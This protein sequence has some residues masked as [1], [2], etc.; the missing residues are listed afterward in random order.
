MTQIEI[1]NKIYDE[2]NGNWNITNLHGV[3]LKNCLI[4]PIKQKYYSID[5]E[6]EVEL[7]TVLEESQDHNGYK[8]FYDEVEDCYGLGNLYN[9]DKNQSNNFVLTSL[10][11]YGTFLE[12]LEMM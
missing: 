1:Q 8:I 5:K 11:L 6:Q 2:I 10:G 9:L 4:T 12:T 3:N 7:W